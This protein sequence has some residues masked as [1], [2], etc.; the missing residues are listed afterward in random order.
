MEETHV[1][2]VKQGRVTFRDAGADVA[3]EVEPEGHAECH[4]TAQDAAEVAQLLTED[5]R[6]VWGR[7]ER[8]PGRMQLPRGITG[9]AWR[10]E[11]PRGHLSVRL[12]TAHQHVAMR[13]EGATAAH[14]PVE[15]AV[16]LIQILQHC[17]GML[18]GLE[19]PGD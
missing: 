17:A 18:E 14:L 5:A 1:W 2:M 19:G 9:E 10:W 6:A 12:D 11:T 15:T 16:E 8:T 3:L 13:L 7:P 4:L